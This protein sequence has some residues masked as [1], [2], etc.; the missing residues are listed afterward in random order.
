MSALPEQLIFDLGHRTAHDRQD[1]LISSANQD[2][3][4]WIDQWPNWP[5]PALIIHGPAASGKTHL[6]AVWSNQTGAKRIHSDIL[7]EKEADEIAGLAR[8][9]T[10]D[11]VDLWIGDKDVETTLFHLYNIMKEEGRTLLLTMRMA[12]SR[13]DFAI[14]DL[15]S[16]LRAA[17]VVTIQPPDDPLLAALLVKQFSDRQLQ[18]SAD[19]LQYILPRMERSF[20]ATYQLVDKIDKLA[21]SEKRSISIPLIRRIFLEE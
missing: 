20:S 18:I 21:L 2:A 14:A 15:A 6:A 5:A 10:I 9:L 8:H 4:G 12:P 17:P 1:F 13:A 11:P 7:A 16:R 19:V 3:V